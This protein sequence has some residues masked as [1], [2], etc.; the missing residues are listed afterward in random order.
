VYW[1]KDSSVV[2][3]IR[4]IPEVIVTSGRPVV[5]LILLFLICLAANQA[6]Q[7]GPSIVASDQ[8]LE[9]QLPATYV[10]P[11]KQTY[12]EY[13]AACHGLDGKGHGPAAW[14]LRKQPPN[15]T[16]I[17]K[18]HGGKFPDEYVEGVLQFGPGF[19]AHG[20]SEM[21]VWG[22]IF[23]YLENYNEAA[24]RQRIK[25]LCDFLESIQEK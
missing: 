9:D 25:N 5:I 7:V 23:R 4:K 16:T 19:S 17:A 15:L 21:P 6:S 8:I 12:K 11:G 3:G 14:S 18:R 1:H 20:S 10:P 22:P 13:C 2:Q 24:V